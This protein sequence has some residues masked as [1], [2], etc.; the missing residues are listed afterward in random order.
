MHYII[1]YICMYIYI[2]VYVYIYIYIYIHTHGY[3]LW[4]FLKNV[5][6]IPVHVINML[7]WMF[8]KFILKQTQ[9][10]KCQ[11]VAVAI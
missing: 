9:N 8:V 4:I 7:N 11:N 3:A 5:D 10:W 2:Y 1:R 6:C